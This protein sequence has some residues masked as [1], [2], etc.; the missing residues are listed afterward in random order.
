MYIPK[1]SKA[2]PKGKKFTPPAWLSALYFP[3]AV[4]YG[5]LLLRLFDKDISFFG[6]GLW[7]VLFF[8]IAA[9]LLAYFLLSILPWRKVSLGIGIGLLAFGTVI[10]CVEYCCKVF[11]QIY[12]P[13]RYIFNMSGQAAG[14][15]MGNIIEVIIGSIPFILLSLVPLVAFILLRK[16]FFTK[17]NT[18]Y[19]SW[20]S[21]LI[22][23]FLLQMLGV[24]TSTTAGI[25]PLYTYDFASNTSVSEFGLLTTLRLESQYDWFG[26]RDRTGKNRL[27]ARGKGS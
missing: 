2:T 4:L 26:N 18:N 27:S 14:D 20:M 13:L 16:H 17:Q 25:N 5:E 19:L 24:L 9:G 10:L 7:R 8:S 22:V 3:G 1:Y 23:V 12:F 11:F 6:A 15:F 21:T